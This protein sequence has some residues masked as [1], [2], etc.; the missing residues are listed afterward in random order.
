[1][2]KPPQYV[3]REDVVFVD[4]D[5]KWIFREETPLGAVYVFTFKSRSSG[6]TFKSRAPTFQFGVTPRSEGS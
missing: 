5:T 3:N 6:F 2:T 4:W 1:V